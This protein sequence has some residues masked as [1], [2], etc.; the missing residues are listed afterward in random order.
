MGIWISALPSAH[1]LVDMSL[2]FVFLEI[3]GWITHVLSFW[4][5]KNTIERFRVGTLDCT[6]TLFYILQNACD[7]CH[8][9]KAT[10]SIRINRPNLLPHT[11]IVWNYSSAR[12]RQSIESIFY[13]SPK[14]FAKQIKKA[15]FHT[16]HH[17][18]EDAEQ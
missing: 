14:R 7:Q 11:S 2:L 6:C 16:N 18:F 5:T 12:K 1:S 9:S 3:C 10:E 4:R 17:A 8:D 13:S 15:D